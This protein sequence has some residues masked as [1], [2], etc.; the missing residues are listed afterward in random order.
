M[1]F[2]PGELPPK[3]LFEEKSGLGLIIIV[4]CVLGFLIVLIIA[5]VYANNYMDRKAKLNEIAD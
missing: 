1:E 5:G 3:P 2:D 4:I